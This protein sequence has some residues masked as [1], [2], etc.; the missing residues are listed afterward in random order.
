MA[1]G[2]DLDYKMQQVSVWI[3][4][5]YATTEIG[6]WL[7]NN[8]K[9]GYQEVQLSYDLK[10]SDYIHDLHAVV[11][12]EIYNGKVMEKDEA[13]QKCENATA[14]GKVCVKV[15]ANNVKP[16]DINIYRKFNYEV[17]IPSGKQ[18]KVWLRYSSI[19]FLTEEKL[20]YALNNY[21]QNSNSLQP[22]R[23]VFQVSISEIE[24]LKSEPKLTCN[25]QD[26]KIRRRS[27]WRYASPRQPF[28]SHISPICPQ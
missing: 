25:D 17:R 19:I 9:T 1:Y 28:S 7:Q 11:G 20:T 6:I 3:E 14:N 18:L 8:D 24:N 2:Q 5:R 23:E 13:D 15:A 21:L 26:T 10:R 22:D 16:K 4:H 27:Q 12:N